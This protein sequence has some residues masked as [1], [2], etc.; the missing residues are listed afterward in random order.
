MGTGNAVLGLATFRAE[1]RVIRRKIGI[2][3]FAFAFQ[4]PCPA[5]LANIGSL[6]KYW[7]SD[8]HFEYQFGCQGWLVP[9][10]LYFAFVAGYYSP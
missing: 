10:F 4:K 9:V 6:G 2:A 1:Q 7:R 5:R 3:E 8:R